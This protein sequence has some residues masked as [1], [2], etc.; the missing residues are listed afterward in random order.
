MDFLDNLYYGNINPNEHVFARNNKKYKKTFEKYLDIAND[1]ENRLSGDMK[2]CFERLDKASMD[3]IE[4]TGIENFKLGFR[5]G[6]NMMCA[7]MYDGTIPAELL[8][9]E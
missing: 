8:F 1:F 5:L 2:Q 9:K 6:V 4:L 3:C 7:C